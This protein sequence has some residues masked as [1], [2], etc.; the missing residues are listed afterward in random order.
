MAQPLQPL[1][2]AAPAFKGLNT[3]DSPLSGDPQ[4][5]S[6]A[7]NVVVDSYG[8]I[9]SR[10]GLNLLTVDYTEL[11]TD[12]IHV[13]HEYEDALGNLKIFSVGNSKILSGTT[14]LVDETPATYTI[15]EQHFQITNFNDHCYFFNAGHEPLVY[16]TA[17]GAVTK[18]SAVSGA[19][20]TPPQG[21]AVLA[22]YGRLWVGGVDGE[23]NMVYWSDLLAGHK[24]DTGT[25]GSLNLDK[26]WPDGSDRV[27]AL[28]AWNG[29]LVIFGYN[30]IVLYQGAESP[31][32]MN[33]VDTI[34]GIGCVSRNT[35]KLTGTDL[36]FM[37]ARGVMSLGRTIQE[38][39]APL[40]DVSKNVRDDII[41]L[42]KTQDEEIYAA[43]NAKYSFYLLSFPTQ[44]VVYCFDVRAPLEDGSFR[45]TRWL[46][47]DM[48]CFKTIQN[49]DL[50]VGHAGGISRYE[51]YQD[52]GQPYTMR[53]YSNPLSFG[54]PT[55][56]KFLKKIAP[57]IIGGAAGTFSVKWS[58][59]FGTDYKAQTYTLGGSIIAYYN[60]SEYNDAEYT[61]GVQI[62]TPRINCSGSGNLITIG[63]EAPINGAPISLQEFNIQATT[64][65]IY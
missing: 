65:R 44:D 35:V 61:A 6:V 2:I 22:A 10:R 59:D 3:Q 57:T 52:I 51:G 43:Y 11:G 19:S 31:A 28:A 45:V 49:D 18:M 30:S 17:L 7:D 41:Q 62:T 39:S 50:L 48:Y 26:V 13:L 34:V 64:G 5:A 54:N 15:T 58:Y 33:L 27:V 23:P 16:S 40:R 38:K 1:N 21:S 25:A 20:G 9:G 29:Y 55:Q 60:V 4:Y 47:P 63:L 14:T 32:T 12:K 36:L 24:W 8:R 53:Y 42:W 56:L 37:S 46:S